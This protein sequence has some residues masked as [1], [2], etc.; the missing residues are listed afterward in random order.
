V[1][2][3][4]VATESGREPE[5]GF[6][7]VVCGIDSSGESLDA[8]RQGIALAEE[9][10]QYWA[11]SAWDPGPAVHAGVQAFDLM[12][13]LRDESRTALRRAKEALPEL[14]PILFKG[15]D[16]PALLAAI[17]NLEADLVCVGSHGTSRPA[18]VV[19]GSVASAMAHFATCSTLVA[20]APRP[21]GFPGLILHANDG[22][23]ESLTAARVAAQIAARHASTIVTLH[24]GEDGQGVA[25]E[26]VAIIETSGREPVMQVEQGSPHRRIVEV[27][28]ETNASLVVMG[29]RGQT[30][31]KALGSVSERVTH[32]AGCSVL[33]VRMAS[34][35]ARDED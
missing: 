13:Q 12:H 21:G 25:E 26:A 14:Q 34:H 9:G 28:N 23:P 31:L 19:F 32:R 15:R 20:R 35:P 29:S 8:A 16:I 18:G 2:D 30:G 24:V 6:R 5:A 7:N 3:E 11:V 17:A 33:I 4:N 27:G 10:A 22:S 1:P